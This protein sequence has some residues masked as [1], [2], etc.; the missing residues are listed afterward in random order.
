LSVVR[1]QIQNKFVELVE[2][3]ELPKAEI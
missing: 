2:L 3:V 1:R